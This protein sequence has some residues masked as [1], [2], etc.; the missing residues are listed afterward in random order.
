MFHGT[1]PPVSV[2]SLPPLA[3]S[4]PQKGTKDFRTTNESIKVVR[5]RNKS[6]PLLRYER[7]ER[8]RLEERK[9]A[10]AMATVFTQNREI[11]G[12]GGG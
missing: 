2:Q 1:E 3:F 11:G 9:Y 10:C 8:E 7:N 5:I 6:F 12:K 4:R